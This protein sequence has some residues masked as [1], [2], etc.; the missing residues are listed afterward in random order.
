ML[1]VFGLQCYSATMWN[2][3]EF[4]GSRPVPAGAGT[5]E[6]RSTKNRH[7]QPK[8]VLQPSPRLERLGLHLSTLAGLS[9]PGVVAMKPRKA[10][11]MQQTDKERKRER[12]REGDR[13]GGRK[14]A[15]EP[16]GRG[17]ERGKTHRAFVYADHT[18]V[19]VHAYIHICMSVGVSVCLCV[20]KYVCLFVSH[21]LHAGSFPKT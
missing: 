6:P 19:H 5:P 14:A 16:R 9:G 18:H 10:G 11:R 3:F 15:R 12:E 21:F 13:E 17:G 20:S 2:A 1:F 8:H 7:A 4:A